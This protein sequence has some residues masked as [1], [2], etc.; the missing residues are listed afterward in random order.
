MTSQ[1]GS[2]DVSVDVRDGRKHSFFQIDNE[3]IDHYHLTYKAL[4]AYMVLVRHANR[5]T[6]KTLISKR[7]LSEILRCTDGTLDN[8]LNELVE[9]DLLSVRSGKKQGKVN[10][11]TLLSVPKKGTPKD[12]VPPDSGYP[13]RRGRG[14]HKDGVGV[15]QKKGDDQD[16]DQDSDQNSKR[17]RSSKPKF[18]KAQMTPIKDEIV[19]LFGWDPDT[20]TVNEW[21]VV[22]KAAHSWLT[23]Q[24]TVDELS[25][26]FA[27][28]QTNFPRFGPAA[29]ASHR[30]AALRN[31]HTIP[32]P[33]EAQDR[34]RTDDDALEWPDTLYDEQGRPIERGDDEQE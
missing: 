29:L 4:A 15:P 24:G 25:T 16:L 1:N 30:Q 19:R 33:D 9:A 20:M 13:K 21:G 17:A 11:Y 34:A 7:R 31:G 26:V 28:C 14:T 6:E 12:R 18:T 10:T 23:G 8:A 22:E 32:T 3:V 5:V 27:Y 2:S